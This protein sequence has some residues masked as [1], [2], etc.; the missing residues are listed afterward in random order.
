MKIQQTSSRQQG[1][2]QGGWLSALQISPCDPSQGKIVPMDY[3]QVTGTPCLCLKFS[4]GCI[5]EYSRLNHERALPRSSTITQSCGPAPDLLPTIRK[6]TLHP[7]VGQ[8]APVILQ[9][10]SSQERLAI[11]FSPNLPRGSHWLRVSTGTQQWFNIRHTGTA[12][13]TFHSEASYLITTQASPYIAIN[14]EVTTSSPAPLRS[15]HTFINQQ[16]L[17]LAQSSFN[18]CS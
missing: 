3:F 15:L 11:S 12:V 13:H 7:W 14:P 5:H 1:A 10:L 16:I 4:S 17:C 2:R 6:P 8:R 18:K 9:Q